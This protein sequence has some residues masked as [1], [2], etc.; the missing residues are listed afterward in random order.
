MDPYT[1]SLNSQLHMLDLGNAD[2]QQQQ[3]QLQ[4]QNQPHEEQQ[5]NE[6]FLQLTLQGNG[7]G[8][9]EN[10]SNCQNDGNLPNDLISLKNLLQMRIKYTRPKH[11]GY[12]EFQDVPDDVNYLQDCI[13]FIDKHC[14]EP[15]EE[16]PYKSVDN[17]QIKSLRKS[18]YKKYLEPLEMEPDE[19]DMEFNI[20]FFNHLSF[21][22]VRDELIEIVKTSK[23]DYL[24][25]ILIYRR[26][27]GQVI[28]KSWEIYP[29]NKSISQK[30]YILFFDKMDDLIKEWLLEYCI[31]D[32]PIRNICSDN[33]KTT[34]DVLQILVEQQ[35]ISYQIK[36]LIDMLIQN[37]G[38]EDYLNADHGF[39]PY[40]TYIDH[41][42][43]AIE[44]SIPKCNNPYRT[45]MLLILVIKGMIK[46]PMLLEEFQV[47]LEEFLTIH[48]DFTLGELSEFM[49]QYNM[50]NIGLNRIE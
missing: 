13:R 48:P 31:I 43:T 29:N 3:L 15:N 44:T 8:N 11:G 7:N 22:S 5:I 19:L 28:P 46:F 32:R 30:D 12:W 4:L 50:P 18:Y 24:L 2:S 42:Q 14:I 34:Y 36:V 35:N 41:I 39:L 10:N 6:G 37:A 38:S 1:N 9:Y 26:A 20:R 17:R 16:N 23:Y 25:N 27:K 21:K 45:A 47:R 33:L 49:K 40:L